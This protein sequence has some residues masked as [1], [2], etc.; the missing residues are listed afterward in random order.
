MTAQPR[1]VGKIGGATLPAAY[2][3]LIFDLGRIFGAQIGFPSIDS[4]DGN[5]CFAG[6]TRMF[7]YEDYK[8]QYPSWF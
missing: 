8:K 6:C 7:S 2:M 3:P 1:W 4:I 5:G